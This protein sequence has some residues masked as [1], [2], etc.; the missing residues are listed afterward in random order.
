[1]DIWVR[2]EDVHI[3]IID[4]KKYLWWGR[5]NN[6]KYQGADLWWHGLPFNRHQFC[7]PW[8]D[9]RMPLTPPGVQCHWV[10]RWKDWR[11]CRRTSWATPWKCCLKANIH[12]AIFH[13]KIMSFRAVE[14]GN[15]VLSL[16][17]FVTFS[18]AINRLHYKI[19]IES[20]NIWYFT[21]SKDLSHSGSRS[22][23]YSRTC[24]D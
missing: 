14:R 22:T 1:M 18:L 13:V 5:Y 15:N 16:I 21:Y 6:I 7:G 4:A 24:M 10:G 3:L 19:L 17:V 2:L 20:R 12:S 8:Q 11:R 23:L 9:S